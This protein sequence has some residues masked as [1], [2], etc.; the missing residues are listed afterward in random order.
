MR[1][2]RGEGRELEKET[3][4]EY[5]CVSGKDNVGVRSLCFL[6]NTGVSQSTF[7]VLSMQLHGAGWTPRDQILR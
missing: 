1:E 5:V 2:R 6:I 4:R 3:G 7:H